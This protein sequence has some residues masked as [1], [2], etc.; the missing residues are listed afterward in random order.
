M[1]ENNWKWMNKI[2]WMNEWVNNYWPVVLMF[3]H[4]H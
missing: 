2:E 3:V 1:N 4:A